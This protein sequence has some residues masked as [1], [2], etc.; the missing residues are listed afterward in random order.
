[1]SRRR[2][3]RPETQFDVVRL[4]IVCTHH[5][6]DTTRV[7]R[8]GTVEFWPEDGR[9]HV[10]QVDA[11]HGSDDPFVNFEAPLNPHFTWT[12][13][14]RRCPEVR[15]LTNKTL[16]LVVPLL[17][18]SGVTRLDICMVGAVAARVREQ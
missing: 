10:D 2:R 3:G 7:A 17:V 4:P 6:P 18:Q 9:V 5:E 13:R 8:L 11:F 16:D 12:F 14:C 1:M 15:P